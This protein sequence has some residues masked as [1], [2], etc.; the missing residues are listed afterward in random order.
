MFI[1]RRSVWSFPAFLFQSKTRVVSTKYGRVQGFVSRVGRDAEE[2]RHV[3]ARRIHICAKKRISNYLNV[4]QVF[5]GVPYASPPVGQHRWDVVSFPGSPLGKRRKCVTCF[6]VF[7]RDIIWQTA[8]QN[9][10]K[11]WLFHFRH[12]TIH[13]HKR[14]FPNRPCR[15]TLHFPWKNCRKNPLKKLSRIN[16]AN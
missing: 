3:Q 4:F 11:E 5:L 1:F 8:F 13:H 10:R 15:T 6:R 2:Q 12:A 9:G 16:P 7:S 14:C